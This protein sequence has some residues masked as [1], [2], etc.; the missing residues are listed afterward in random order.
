MKENLYLITKN[1]IMKNHTDLEQSKKLAEILPLESADM[2]Y[3][4]D[5]DGSWFVDLTEYASIKIPKYVDNIEEHLQPCWS[6]T[7]LLNV[8]PQT[9]RL[10]G[11]SK[12]SYWYCECVNGN[13]QSYTGFGSADNPVDACV[14][15]ILKLDKLKML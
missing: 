7:A 13:N 14:E 2:H 11:T 1:F 5:F 8:L 15:M 9:V 6:L 4:K 3:A 12:D 10:V